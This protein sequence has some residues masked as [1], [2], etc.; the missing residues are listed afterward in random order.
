MRFWWFHAENN[1]GDVLTPHIL[2][3][4]GV[5]ARWHHRDKANAIMV[6]SIAKWARPGMHVF[7]SGFIR[8]AD[9]AC[10]SATYHWVRG[11]LSR[12]KIL[13]AGGLCHEKY[14]DPAMLLPDLWAPSEKKHEVGIVPHHVD[15]AEVV[16]T[17]LH[18]IDLTQPAEQVTA[19]ITECRTII[20]SSLH[21]I[22]AAHA[23]GIPAAWV[24]FSDRLHGDGLKF[25]D[26]YASLGLEAKLSTLDDP[27]FQVGNLDCDHMRRTLCSL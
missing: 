13:A 18:V 23:Y 17:G 9:I 22:I 12:A 27:E 14:G 15:Y 20:S 4:F 6:G 5:D 16:K 21:G 1:Y 25:R 7:G 26:H 24:K 10:K 11:P 3:H 19:Q 8:Q 2:K